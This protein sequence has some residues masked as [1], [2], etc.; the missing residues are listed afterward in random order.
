MLSVVQDL[1]RKVM[2]KT[3]KAKGRILISIPLVVEVIMVVILVILQRGYQ[4]KLS[5]ERNLREIVTRTNHMWV[6][7]TEG[8]ARYA[9]YGIFGGTDSPAGLRGDLEADYAEISKLLVDQP[10]LKTCID[11]ARRHIMDAVTVVENY[12]RVDPDANLASRLEALRAN[13]SL[14]AQATEPINS[15]NSK[16]LEFE[17]KA[18]FEGRESADDV[19]DTEEDIDQ[20][21]IAMVG[22]SAAIALLLFFLISN[23]ILRRLDLL[24]ENTEHFREGE[25]LRDLLTGSDEL[26]VLDTAF[27]RMAKEISE[28]QQLKQTMISTISHDVRTPLAAISM[29][30]ELLTMGT[31]GTEH[32]GLVEG[33]EAAE[34][35]VNE[36]VSLITVL[37]DLEKINAGRMEIS[38]E[39]VDVRR[40]IDAAIEK[41]NDSFF[42][43][44]IVFNPG[45]SSIAAAGTLGTEGP[46]RLVEVD[47]DRI[48]QVL[49]ILMRNALT[50]A[51]DF[52][53]DFAVVQSNDS[54]EVSISQ[55][56]SAL[57]K[58]SIEMILAGK[59][60][61]E[62]GALAVG[63]PLGRAILQLHNGDIGVTAGDTG[64]T[65]WLHIGG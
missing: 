62:L 52:R 43:E 64:N 58:A 22:G 13:G 60:D 34:R 19:R 25:K 5:D 12:H 40:L 20:F 44:R 16:A 46:S 50:L 6:H 37:L 3:I 61:T 63:F 18:V 48:V 21:L 27:H 54:T 32:G 10:E 65:F 23:K 35:D 15:F 49:E 51:E 1:A 56:G 4:E 33:A 30:L 38:R 36:V 29:Y 9:D 26:A 8:L 53:L 17:K 47:Q 45:A 41:F 57:D 11:D 7:F 28:A 42:D 31:I 14:F 2:P 55:K 59:A 24:L 39:A